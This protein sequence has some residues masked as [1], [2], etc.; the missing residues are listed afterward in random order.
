ML[1]PSPSGFIPAVQLQLR[2][3]FLDPFKDFRYNTMDPSKQM[4]LSSMFSQVLLISAYLFFVWFV[5]RH[6]R[7]IL[8]DSAGFLKLAVAH[9]IILAFVSLVLLLMLSDQARGLCASH[10]HIM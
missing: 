10:T 9:N 3:Y 5:R 6:Y 2:D 8:R 1:T 7:G 4:P